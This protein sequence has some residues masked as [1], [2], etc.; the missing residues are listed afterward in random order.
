MFNCHIY[1]LLII[2]LKNLLSFCNIF[3]CFTDFFTIADLNPRY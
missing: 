1:Y 3:Y 2:F